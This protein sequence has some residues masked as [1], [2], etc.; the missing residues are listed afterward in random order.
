VP[1]I[2]AACGGGAPPAET[3]VAGLSTACMPLY[4]PPTYQTIFDKVFH[5]TC[6]AGKGTCHSADG[7]KA[8]LV[9][10]DADLAYDLLLG[11]TGGRARVLP[12][13]PA[14]SILEMRLESQDPNFRMPA[15]PTPL[16]PSERCMITQWIANGAAR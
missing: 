7:A 10:E 6:A 5:P 1:F 9:F 15:G 4:D 8:G 12:H 11:K 14:C 13:D 3:C 16:L 2:V